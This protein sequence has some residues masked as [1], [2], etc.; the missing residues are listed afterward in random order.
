M[1]RAGWERNADLSRDCAVL[2]QS[3]QLHGITEYLLVL[4]AQ[5]RWAHNRRGS[6]KSVGSKID[7]RIR[8]YTE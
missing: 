3:V 7:G 2:L 6:A 4:C 1:S 8:E 5:S